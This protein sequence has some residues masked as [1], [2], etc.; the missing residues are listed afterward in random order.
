MSDAS[1]R[2]F[3]RVNYPCQLTMWMPEGPYDTV[4]TNALD[5]GQGGL[6]VE[7]NRE[8]IQ[9]MKVD[10]EID[11]KDN[12]APFRCKGVVVR[13]QQEDNKHYYNI[14]IQFVSLSETNQAALAG[15]IS[16]IINLKEK[17]NS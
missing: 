7:M 14:G 12:T 9:G 16:Q 5:I 10:I 3:P 2:K 13:C 17:D 11:F 6:C 15:K 1:Q 8:V 4:L